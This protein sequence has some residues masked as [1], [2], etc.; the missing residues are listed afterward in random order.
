M[1]RIPS[2]KYCFTKDSRLPNQVSLSFNGLWSGENRGP[3]RHHQTLKSDADHHAS[4]VELSPFFLFKI[5]HPLGRAFHVFWDPAFFWRFSIGLP[6]MEILSRYPLWS[7]PSLALPWLWEL[8]SEF[9]ELVCGETCGLFF[10]PKRDLRHCSIGPALRY[11]SITG[12]F[13]WIEVR[14]AFDDI[15]PA[16]GRAP[17][18]WW[19]LGWFRRSSQT[20]RHSGLWTAAAVDVGHFIPVSWSVGV[21]VNPH[22]MHGN[23]I[24]RWINMYI[25]IYK[26]IDYMWGG[27]LSPLVWVMGFDLTVFLL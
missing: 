2:N 27:P 17:S 22:I 11:A 1:V 4:Q 26:Y 14:D 25:Y 20:P 3:F 9:V 21:L 6:L 18:N 12:G 24:Y 13:T 15:S 10:T 23:T 5:L 8:M 16:W 19:T 7:G